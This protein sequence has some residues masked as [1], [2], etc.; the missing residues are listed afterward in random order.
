MSTPATCF[1]VEDTGRW[2][3]WLRRYS[4]GSA[5]PRHGYH[6]ALVPFDGDQEPPRE[7]ARWPTT[8]PCGYTFVAGDP[9]QLFR[10]RI[11]RRP[12]NGDEWPQRDLP[13]GALY[14]AEWLHEATTDGRRWVGPD[15]ISLCVVLPG[16][17]PHGIPIDGPASTR[18]DQGKALWWT[19][20]GDPRRPETLTVSPSI[21]PNAPHGWHGFLQQGRL[22][23][24]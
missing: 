15:G 22:V 17:Q 2:A 6:N 3:R 1:W 8:C 11:Y 18:D 20:T 14:D 5:C 24:A 7:D 4:S 16:T 19:R 12:D 23:P 13:V 21:W 9:Y 10:E